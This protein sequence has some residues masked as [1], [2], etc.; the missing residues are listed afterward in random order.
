M[1]RIKIDLP[2][3]FIFSTEIPVRI[4]DL[5]YGNHVG[6]DTILSIAHELRMQWLWSIGY[7]SELAIEGIGLIMVDAGISFKSELFY[8]ETVLGS[9]A[10]DGVS[11]TGFDV[12][13]KLE[14]KVLSELQLVAIAKTGML[15]FDYES[16][17]IVQT[18]E[19]FRKKLI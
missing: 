1:S 6:N 16:R 3:H 4:T 5:N 17:K 10:I 9:L 14:K 12:Y 11:K 18:P 2:A 19:N 8:G 13:Y 7:A 15:C